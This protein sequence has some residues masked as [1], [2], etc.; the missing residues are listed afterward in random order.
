MKYKTKP[1]KDE[2]QFMAFMVLATALPFPIAVYFR[3]VDYANTSTVT[4]TFG[5]IAEL[6]EW[7]RHFAVKPHCWDDEK[8]DVRHAV[9]A[10]IPW[11]G[12]E[13]VLTA[14]DKAR[15]EAELDTADAKEL[16]RIAMAKPA[17][18]G[19]GNPQCSAE[20]PDGNNCVG[21]DGHPDGSDHANQYRTWKTDE[22]GE[23]V[24]VTELRG[25]TPP[26][27][28]VSLAEHLE[29]RK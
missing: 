22:A 6:D 8:R 5:S 11:H 7:A 24:E 26:A 17:E 3:P 27:E 23:I 4:I 25:P 1:E 9:A 13:V 16:S 15:Q 20:D 29:D 21:P 14:E 19:P 2:R 12:W 28:R 10:G 18:Y